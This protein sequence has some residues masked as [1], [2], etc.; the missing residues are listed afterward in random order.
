M[1]TKTTNVFFVTTAALMLAIALAAC[2]PS[3]DAQDQRTAQAASA[4]APSST[5][6]ADTPPASM[7]PPASAQGTNSAETASN[8]DA[9]MQPMSK[10]EETK[11][12][13]KPGQANDH[14]TV[15]PAQTK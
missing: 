14:S 13:P 4:P 1:K 11:A 15:S 5:P 3:N 12:M 8:S 9:A 2:G 7:P 10:D 6:P